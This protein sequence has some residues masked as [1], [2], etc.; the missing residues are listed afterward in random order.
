MKRIQCM[1][2]H[3]DVHSLSV[4]FVKSDVIWKMSS[5]CTILQQPSPPRNVYGGDK[6]LEVIHGVFKDFLDTATLLLI[7]TCHGCHGDKGIPPGWR[8]VFGG[9][10]WRV[11][12]AGGIWRR[13]WGY[14]FSGDEWSPPWLVINHPP[15]LLVDHQ[16]IQR[17]WV[18]LGIDKPLPLARPAQLSLIEFLE[19]SSKRSL[20]GLMSCVSVSM[21]F[22]VFRFH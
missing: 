19:L 9:S 21:L 6:P 18:G 1:R 12:W 2:V 4:L 16:P 10:R 20:W 11:D 5:F 8:P 17:P 3:A 7:I 22:V 15:C 13:I 14:S